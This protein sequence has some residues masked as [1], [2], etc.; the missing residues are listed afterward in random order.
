MKVYNLSHARSRQ[1][2]DLT[3]LGIRRELIKE[4]RLKPIRPLD[5]IH[6]KSAA[7]EKFAPLLNGEEFTRLCVLLRDLA[8]AVVFLMR[9]ENG[10]KIMRGDSAAAREN[11]RIVLDGDPASRC[12]KRWRSCCSIIRSST[13]IP[14][15]S[16]MSLHHLPQSASSA[17]FSPRL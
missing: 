7:L 14:A 16:G 17:I 4:R 12:L 10:P 8:P 5:I 15:S 11:L 6:S 1:L 3:L 13:V 2:H 9:P